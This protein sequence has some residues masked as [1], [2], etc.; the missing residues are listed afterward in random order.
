MASLDPLTLPHQT[1]VLW[2]AVV[3]KSPTFQAMLKAF[4]EREQQAVERHQRWL[5]ARGKK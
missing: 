1:D 2:S 4:E 5:V 3:S